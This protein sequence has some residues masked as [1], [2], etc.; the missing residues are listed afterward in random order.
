MKNIITKERKVEFN[1]GGRVGR[2]I[3][4][5]ID[6]IIDGEYK[7]T[8]II[9][10]SNPLKYG[11][12][13]GVILRIMNKQGETWCFGATKENALNINWIKTKI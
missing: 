10:P 9:E 13:G 5:A 7:A 6:Y 2:K 8:A 4:D 3:L 11:E 12:C 1:Y